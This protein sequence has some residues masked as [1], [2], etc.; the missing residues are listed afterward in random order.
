MH[1]FLTPELILLTLSLHH[2]Y[3]NVCVHT[4]QRGASS[5]AYEK[6]EGKGQERYLSRQRLWFFKH[7]AA[8]EGKSSLQWATL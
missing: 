5:L 4:A 7:I 8:K 1:V 2:M 6:N 3:V